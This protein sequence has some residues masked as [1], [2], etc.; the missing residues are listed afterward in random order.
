M[1]L[2]YS[3]ENTIWNKLSEAWKDSVLCIECFLEELE[4]VCPDQ[5]INVSDFRYMG[6]S[7]HD[8]DYD[9][10]MDSDTY[11]FLHPKFGGTLIDSGQLG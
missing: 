5:E 2:G 6:I 1:W 10:S 3:I 11:I 8:L 7:A 9:K 4:K